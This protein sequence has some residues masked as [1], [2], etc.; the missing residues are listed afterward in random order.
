MKNIAVVGL[1]QIGGSLV[2]ALRKAK[3]NALITGID[4]SLTCRNHLKKYLDRSA[5]SWSASYDTDIIFACMHFDLLKKFLNE[6][7]TEALI[8]DVCSSKEELVKI[9]NRKR[10]RMIGGH[11][12]TGS[13]H[14]G[15]KG[16]NA[17]LF[18]NAPFF[19]CPADKATTKDRIQLTRLLKMIGAS[20]KIV[21]PPQHD[22]AV[23]ITSHLPALI[24]NFYAHFANGIPVH[25]QGPGF[26]SFT[27]P[28][29][30]SLELLQT[31]R[32]SNRKNIQKTASRFLRQ[33][34]HLT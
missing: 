5:A 12:M 10:L 14:Q 34:S 7:K 24:A 18:R 3:V 22:R 6:A 15:E 21:D 17:D 25:F 8:V 31:F 30:C 9:A 29:K 33:L 23:A 4:P 20:P 2:L 28:G 26:K 1:G 32:S 13:E 16:W 27:R 19:L 11:P